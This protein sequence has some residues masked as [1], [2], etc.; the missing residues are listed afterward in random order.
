MAV[1]SSLNVC[2]SSR[3]QVLVVHFSHL[4]DDLNAICHFKSRSGLSL[5]IVLAIISE[6]FGLFGFLG[7]TLLMVQFDSRIQLL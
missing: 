1:S 5:K 3:C 4:C 2:V 7:V 6:N